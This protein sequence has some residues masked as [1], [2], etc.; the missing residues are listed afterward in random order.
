MSSF[1]KIEEKKLQPMSKFPFNTLDENLLSSSEYL[2]SL[3]NMV[4]EGKLCRVDMD[5]VVVLLLYYIVLLLY[6]SRQI[7]TVYISALFL[8]DVVDGL[9]VGNNWR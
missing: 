2:F 4:T 9:H 1:D 8:S 5:Q 6:V 3:S 7:V